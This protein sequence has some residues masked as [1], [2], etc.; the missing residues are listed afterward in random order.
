[1]LGSEPPVSRLQRVKMFLDSPF[2]GG[3][4]ALQ[5]RPQPRRGSLTRIKKEFTKNKCR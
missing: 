2:C 3:L 1:M 4:P 5:V